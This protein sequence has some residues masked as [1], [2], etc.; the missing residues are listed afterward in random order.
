MGRGNRRKNTSGLI[1]FI[2]N[3]Q[4]TKLSNILFRDIYVTKA[5]MK[6]NGLISTIFK[7][8][9]SLEGKRHLEKGSESSKDIGFIS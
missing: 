4:N 7:I 9:G 2:Q 1:T 6:I 3:F 8:T 5:I